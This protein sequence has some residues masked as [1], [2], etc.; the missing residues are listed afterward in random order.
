MK[1]SGIAGRALTFQSKEVIQPGTE[2]RLRGEGMPKKGS[3]RGDLILK[4]KVQ[5]PERLTESQRE[6]FARYF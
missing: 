5:F 4:F 3:G 1:L 6:T 2:R